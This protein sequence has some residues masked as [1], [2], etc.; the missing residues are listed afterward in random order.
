MSRR[1]EMIE[2][3]VDNDIDSIMADASQNDLLVLAEILCTGFKGYEN[4]T[5]DELVQEMNERGLW[6]IHGLR[7]QY[8]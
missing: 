7:R 3:L 1:H 4:F 5:D 2:M 8:E 6:A